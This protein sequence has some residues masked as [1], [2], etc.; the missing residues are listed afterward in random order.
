MIT[1]RSRRDKSI[2]M[3]L[4]WNLACLKPGRY[5]WKVK[6]PKVSW[7]RVPMKMVS[8]ARKL[9]TIEERRQ[10]QICLFQRG[11]YKTEAVIP[12]IC[13]GFESQW[14]CFV[15][16]GNQAGWKNRTENKTVCIA[17]KFIDLKTLLGSRPGV[18][19]RFMN[20]NIFL[21][22]STIRIEWSGKW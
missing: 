20:N 3:L 21:W 19:V 15:Y 5:F 17:T 14:R 6:I 16:V 4:P 9:S 2:G 13:P 8:V 11:D 12:N 18:D 7:V 22:Y 10:D 1:Y